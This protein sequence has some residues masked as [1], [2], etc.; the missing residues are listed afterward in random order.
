MAALAS[1]EMG[2][3]VRP[4][5][6]AQSERA[7]KR[8]LEPLRRRVLSP[9]FTR[10]GYDLLPAVPEWEHRPLSTRE[11]DRLVRGAAH[12]IG[13]D[14]ESAGISAGD[15]EPLVRQFF[16]AIHGCPVRQKH[17]GNGFNGALELF[18]VARML[19][20]DVIIESGVFRGL[21]TWVLRQACPEARLFCFDAVF[22]NLQ[23]RDPAATYSEADWS[24]YDF[25]DLDLS[26]A[27]VL[28]DD[29]IDQARRL[30][31]A[32]RRGLR[33]L[34]FDD[35]T[36]A[37]C[38]HAH[39]GPAFPTIDMVLSDDLGDEPVRWRRNGREFVYVPDPAAIA[40]LRDR[41]ELARNLDD[42]HGVTGY[43]PARLTYC[44]LKNRPV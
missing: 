10:L 38:I 19:D 3:V 35:N 42:L 5:G 36:P 43:S 44:K 21:T 4:F 13:E 20:P 26:R 34:V 14:L 1:Q 15:V 33:H 32:D 18:V 7:R 9:F 37:H 22:A 39:G 41:V 23:H 11:V 16:D 17:G 27:L 28:F 25:G 30:A 31:E 8:V 40:A 24:L 2:R 6:W 29:H 12:R